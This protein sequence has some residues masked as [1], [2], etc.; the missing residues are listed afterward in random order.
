MPLLDRLSPWLDAHGKLVLPL[1][2]GG[3]GL[4]VVVAFVRRL[5][6]PSW[7]PDQLWKL[8]KDALRL[9][10]EETRGLSCAAAAARLSVPSSHLKVLL[11]EL[12]Q[13]RFVVAER[14]GGDTV[15]KLKR[16]QGGSAS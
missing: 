1:V 5:R 10:E 2:A 13:D 16:F 7:T 12:I 15:Y 4:A 8:K 14:E 9:F 6:E 3:V 11:E